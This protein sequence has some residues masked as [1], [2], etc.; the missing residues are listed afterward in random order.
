MP[1]SQGAAGTAID[2]EVGARIRS[3]RKILGIS[4]SALGERLGIT[5]QQIQKYEKGRNRVG[6]SRLQGIANVLGTTP[7]GLLG[8]Q[9][10]GS[11]QKTPELEAIEKMIGTSEGA[12]LNRAFARITDT[13]VRKSIIGLITTLGTDVEE[14]LIRPHADRG[15]A[16]CA[17]LPFQSI[18]QP[19]S[20]LRSEAARL[21]PRRR[22]RSSEASLPPEPRA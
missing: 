21:S 2:I 8:E 7:A 6:A 15:G 17:S 19:A 16:K 18:R 10:G 4:Q 20:R 5:F 12:A 9:E 1:R 13:A 11:P 3:R 22:W 14:V